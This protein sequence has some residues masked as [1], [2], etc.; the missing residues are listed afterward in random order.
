MLTALSERY[1]SRRISY[2]ARKEDLLLISNLGASPDPADTFSTGVSVALSV[3][4]IYGMIGWIGKRGFLRNVKFSTAKLAFFL[5]HILTWADVCWIPPRE[6]D[7]CHP[8]T[9]VSAHSEIYLCRIYI[10]TRTK[11]GVDD[12]KAVHDREPESTSCMSSNTTMR[13]QLGLAS[14][15]QRFVY[16]RR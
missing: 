12:D 16:F 11:T 15:V 8:T 14:S 2:T 6:S 7:N 13:Q 4:I 5:F 10:V 9:I 3:S 1:L